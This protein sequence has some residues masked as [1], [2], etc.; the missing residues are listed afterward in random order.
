VTPGPAAEPGENRQEVLD[1]VA[2]VRAAIERIEASDRPEIWIHRAD[3]AELI[4]A[5]EA[6][7]ARL[8]SG[9]SPP[10]AG[11]VAA[12]K[13]NIDVAGW[14]TTAACPAF[15]SVPDRSA[16]VVER[17][18][19]A[20]AVI[21][22]ATNMD[23]FATGLV[24]T[25]SP[26]GAV[27][28]ALFPEYIS[29]GSSSGSAVAV[30]L[31]LVD[32]SLG[33]DTAGSGRVPAAFNGIVGIKPTRG[34]V[35]MEGVL[36]ACRS[37]DCVSVF[38]SNV[39][40]ASLV[41]RSLEG[42]DPS[43][44]WSRHPA[45]TDTPAPALARIGVPS[46]ASLALDT[47]LDDATRAALSDAAERFGALGHQVIE[48]DLDAFLGAG[49][50]LYEGAFLAERYAAVGEFIEQHPDDVDPVVGGIIRSARDLRAHDLAADIDRLAMLSRQ[51]D[52]SWAE[53]DVLVL[54]TTPTV[55]T[56]E[57]IA[58]QPV[59]RNSVL[60]RYTNSCNL[61]DLAAVAV[62]AGERVDAPPV[63]ISLFGP[64]WSDELLAGVAEEFLGVEQPRSAAYAPSNPRSH[65]PAWFRIAVVGAHLAGQPLNG[66]L[67]E[68]GARLV[69]TTTTAAQ[70]RL[71]AL[72][73]TPPKP[74]LVRVE[75]DPVARGSECSDPFGSE[76][77][78]IEVEVWEMD[79]AGFGSFVASIP[80]PLCIGKVLLADGS[81]VSGFL[82]ESA[83]LTAAPDIT[84]SGGWRAHLAA[85]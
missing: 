29:G 9:E 85:D 14:P 30:A 40:L 58:E 33:T 49:A 34:R 70:Y 71:Y 56:L 73:T 72:D 12:V 6:V 80:S 51:A 78:A 60:G 3:D 84:S 81:E 50:L 52:L 64:A 35:S 21:V 46:V 53:V 5:A 32:F 74:G 47:D 57:Q 4:D 2:A 62:P 66:Q 54:P 24:G 63:G 76:G 41:A 16:A 27:R 69:S 61:L 48:V 26:Y 82:C 15:S 11:L 55:Y 42:F 59:A 18:R 1:P 43:D 39:A 8:D 17:L 79:A 19:A 83:A 25:R 65:Q 7:A 28:N 68:R 38:A 67:T 22:G 20:G 75:L 36:P 44:H 77:A 45:P 31:G 10:L 13:N 37:L 23:Q